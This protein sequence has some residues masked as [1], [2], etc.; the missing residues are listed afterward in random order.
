MFQTRKLIAII[1]FLT[2]SVSAISF[3]RI[4][5]INA[6]S[7]GW[8]AT[9]WLQTESGGML[10]VV[11]EREV[12][13]TINVS[14]DMMPDE[15]AR[16]SLV[17]TSNDHQY[18]LHKYYVSGDSS[19][20]LRFGATGSGSCCF[21]SDDLWGEVAE[22][23]ISSFEPNGSRFAVGYVLPMDEAGQ[24]IGGVAVIDALDGSIVA[25]I[26][27]QTI[28]ER[29]NLG[30]ADDRAIL[31]AWQGNNV[32][33]IGYCFACGGGY[34]EG[35]YTLWNPITDELV[36]DGGLTVSAYGA[37]L[38][39]TGE[40][41]YKSQ[42][43]QFLYDPSGAVVPP[44]NVVQY[45]ANGNLDE[46]P[47]VIY[48]NPD[49]LNI[50]GISWVADGRAVLVSNGNG[51]WDIVDRD[52]RTERIELTN[53]Q[54]FMGGTPSG[55]FAAMGDSENRIIVHYSFETLEPTAILPFPEDVL[56]ISVVNFPTLGENL[57]AD[58]FT[59]ITSTESGQTA[60]CPATLPSRLI[61]GQDG[62]VLSGTPNRIR[63]LPNLD[64]EILGEIPSGEIFSVIRGPS[65]GYD[66]PIAWWFVE[67]D[68]VQGWTAEGQDD[69]YF[70]EPVE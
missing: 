23:D 28:A 4:P 66:S 36:A 39:G 48:N 57:T 58:P 15:E 20:H 10:Q 69:T 47:I 14:P 21:L 26:S 1:V 16:S 11:N 40:F 37:S 44:P 6:Q 5:I 33:F 24:H 8:T 42:D 46:E 32:Q 38:D 54:I 2:I 27:M 64:A 68:G 63:D 19:P 55:W 62:I 22:F 18:I 59:A 17:R 60:R 53:Q 52:G 67:Y 70:T 56:S 49:V 43:T 29:L 30:Q 50:G 25:D 3:S 13:E 61:A 51:Y 12:L 7:D 45:F 9:L 31:G 34:I 65:C 41:I 35:T